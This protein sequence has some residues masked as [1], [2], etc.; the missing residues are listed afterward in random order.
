MTYGAGAVSTTRAD[1]PGPALAVLPKTGA[2]P[3][4]ATD[5]RGPRPPPAAG[6]RVFIKPSWK[7]HGSPVTLDQAVRLFWTY[8]DTPSV[9]LKVLHRPVN[10][11][12]VLEELL[13]AFI[14]PSVAPPLQ[15]PDQPVS[16][17]GA[18]GPEDQYPACTAARPTRA[19]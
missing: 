6:E 4:G 9:D 19:G 13:N 8:H 18:P 3:R 17:P 15:H 10:V 16:S 11:T 5:F 14:R 1:M 2:P 7:P 12:G